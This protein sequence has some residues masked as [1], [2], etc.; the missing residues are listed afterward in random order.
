MF[1]L[2]AAMWAALVLAL[3][4]PAG[5]VS[6][7]PGW[8]QATGDMIYSSAALGDLD[9]DGELEVV[10]GCTDGGVYAWDTDGSA[11][12][13][14]P[15]ATGDWLNSSPALGNLDG[16]SQ[17]EVVIGSNDG[18]VYAWDTNGDLLPGWPQVTL[19]S[20]ESSPALAD[21]DGDGHLEVLAGSND[22]QV[23]A[24]HADGSAVA[25]WPVSTARWV[26]DSPAVA[27]LEGDGELEVVAG[28]WDGN[29]YVWHADGTLAA[30]WPQSTGSLM[31]HSPALGDLDGDG[32]LEVVAGSWGNTVWAWH[33]DGSAVAGWPQTTGEAVWSC[34]AL[35]D[36]DSDGALEV[37]AEVGYSDHGGAYAWRADG[38]LVPGWPRST[39]LGGDVYSSPALGDLDGDGKLEVMIGSW[40]GRVYAWHDDGT[41]VAGWPQTLA[42]PVGSSPALGDVDGDGRLEV[43]VG[44]YDSNVYI[45]KCDA[46]TG[47]S[48][49]WPMF[50]HD[51]RR[52][53]LYLPPP[54]VADFSGTP[55]RG[56][57]P[58]SVQFT[59]LSAGA[60]TAWSWDFGDGA[61]S[62]EQD[63]AHTFAPGRHTI[64][65]TVSN[66]G[67]SDRMEKPRYLL[68]T[69]PDVP[70]DPEHWA[71]YQILACVEANIVQGYPGGFYHPEVEVSR[72]QMAVYISRAVAGGDANVQVP[73]GVVEPTF[74]DVGEDHWA[75]RYVEYCAGL[76][77]VQGYWDGTYRPSLVVNRG[78]M[79]VYVARA[80]AEPP[81]DAN[82]PEA[83]AG[84]PTFPDV[85]AEND[86][87]WCYK[88]VEYI[89]GLG[90][91]QGYWDGSYRP[92]RAV[93]RDQMAVYVARAF[94]LPL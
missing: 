29:V 48:L 46:T 81:G 94:E 21:L 52:T 31:P 11:M 30:G 2:S 37:V 56:V 4:S 82:V 84:D 74:A 16:D 49:P 79:A 92:E 93:T 35:G 42:N 68:V 19:G 39:V 86:W 67:G 12:P 58:L 1:R 43:V 15:R 53:G 13:G 77:L 20:V 5:A 73:S 55:T 59:D 38:S 51:A 9:G 33:A 63:P 65:L 83:P 10:I 70:L 23:Y 34:P 76:D 26:N 25:G 90:I 27:D 44:C 14:W 71:L 80:V 47:D 32:T 69:F 57:A 54:P 17:L 24:W 45:W 62:A 36:L 60:P 89:A 40:M 85:T 64:S 3:V 28:S 91:V 18:K 41:A 6:L 50:R 8:P 22:Y 87:S 61:T 75:Y 66:A 88:H 7:Q 72:D 78:Q